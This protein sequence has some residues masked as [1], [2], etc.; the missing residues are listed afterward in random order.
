[1]KPLFLVFEGVDGAGTTTQ[2]NRLCA[3]LRSEGYEF[4]QTREPGGTEIGEQIR[5]LLLDPATHNLDDLAELLLYEASRRQL[6]AQV[7]EPALASGKVV[8]SDRY[9]SSSIAYQGHAR[10]LG[11]ALVQ[12]ANE[13]AT[14]GLAADMTIYLDVDTNTALR[15]RKLRSQGKEDRLEQA[16][17]DFQEKVR[18]AYLEL[19]RD[20]PE[21][22]IL[23]DAKESPDS[24]E[25]TVYHAL[26]DRFSHFP[27]GAPPT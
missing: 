21:Q 14:T 4:V 5:E 7:I 27:Y 11:S 16:G 17:V 3:R 19:A 13:L 20:N 26:I 10:G 18:E 9:T 25:C 15:R 6:I 1:M 12:S 22:S 24:V 8:I 2:C 23:A